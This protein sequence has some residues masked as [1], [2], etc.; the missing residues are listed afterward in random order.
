MADSG[1]FRA[2]RYRGAWLRD[3]LCPL[4]MA[5]LFLCVSAVAVAEP[6]AVPTARFQVVGFSVVGAD[7]LNANEAKMLLASFVGEHEGLDGLLAAADALEQ[8]LA[9][10]GYSF[11]RV[12]LPQQTLR[13]GV[14]RLEI[15]EMKLGNIQL[16]G[17]EHFSRENILASMP[18]LL[19]DRAPNTR[20]LSRALALANEHPA[21]QLRLTFKESPEPGRMDAHLKVEDE[22]PW[23]IFA[24]LNNTGNKNTGKRR[25]SLGIQ[26]NNLFGRDHIANLSYTTSPDQP[27]RVRQWG[28]NYQVPIYPL[29]AS[30]RAYGAKSDVDSG[31]IA[32]LFDVAGAGTIYGLVYTQH[33]HKMGKYRHTLSLGVED[34]EFDN[35]VTVGGGG[36]SITPDIRS[37]PLTLSYAGRYPWS[38]A[39][40]AFD[41]TFAANLD[42]GSTN[43]A[44]DYASSRLGAAQDWKLLRLGI[45]GD[46]LFS[47]DWMLRASARGQYSGEPLINGEQFGVGGLTRCV[48]SMNVRW[49]AIPATT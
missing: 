37:R 31:R 24:S 25:V 9:D 36:V 39:N 16:Q 18:P 46:Y 21:K 27:K 20:L 41:I 23:Q 2:R 34:K 29:A 22:K 43:S 1:S 47:N 35:D 38:R 10:R 3:R 8:R 17:N 48:A 11:H 13:G 15:V 5:S 45:S 30:L 7:P 32:G 40:L 28:L 42:G 33:L 4:A 14:V 26:H 49:R 6:K 44:S 12:S 19:P